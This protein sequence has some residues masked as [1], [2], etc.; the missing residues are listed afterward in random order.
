M[1]CSDAKSN[2]F[3]H[4]ICQLISVDLVNDFLKSCWIF[5]KF[6]NGRE[7]F[8]AIS[9]IMR[10]CR[11]IFK[12]KFFHLLGLFWDSFWWNHT[13][14]STNSEWISHWHCIT[15]KSST[16]KQ[17]E[18]TSFWVNLYM[19]HITLVLIWK[20]EPIFFMVE[21]INLGKEVVMFQMSPRNTHKPSSIRS[22]I[23]QCHYSLI[24]P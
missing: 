24:T 2:K 10:S 19:F 18:V 15:M 4:D 17:N 23:S 3:L 6:W 9:W 5:H 22:C 13:Y 8:K 20:D 12:C 1:L 7:S 14:I 16:V 11:F 21:S